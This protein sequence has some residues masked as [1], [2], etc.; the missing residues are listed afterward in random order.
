MVIAEVSE[1]KPPKAFAA[2]SERQPMKIL[3]RYWLV[4]VSCLGVGTILMVVGFSV[5]ADAPQPVLSISSL[6]NSQFSLVVTNGVATTNYEV[7]W[8]YILANTNVPWQLIGVGSLGE[9]NFTVDTTGWP[10]GFFRVS[11]EQTFN[12][13]PDYQLAD[14]NNPSLGALTITIDS[15]TNGMTFN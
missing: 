4:L 6:G 12:G 2:K 5:F 8:T 11:L 14:P 10:I 3:R 13:I 9:T 1:G 15:P 7:H